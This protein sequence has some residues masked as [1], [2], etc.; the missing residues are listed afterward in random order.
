[1]ITRKVPSFGPCLLTWLKPENTGL[2]LD[3][4][5][6]AGSYAKKPESEIPVA[7]LGRD[8]SV[9]MTISDSPVILKGNIKES[10]I[11]NITDYIIKNKQTI[12]D[13]WYGKICSMELCNR[14]TWA[15]RPTED[16]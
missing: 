7:L 9:I 10:D 11:E 4:Y 1:M 8:S 15:S 5:L 2:P 16:F 13:H 6:I 14:L 3:I 12:L